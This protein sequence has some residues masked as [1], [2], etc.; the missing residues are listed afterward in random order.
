MVVL[1]H[2]HS[3]FLIDL[4]PKYPRD[5]QVYDDEEDLIIKQAFQCLCA[6]CEQEI[7]YLHRYYYKC[8][9]CDYSLHKL[10]EKI[11]TKLQHAS[12]SAHSLTLFLDESLGQCH[13]CKSTPRY[14][15]LKYQCPRC[16]F[17]ICLYCATG[18][19]QYHTIYHPS[20]QH[21][22]IPVCRQRQI[23]AE[24]D[25]CG[26]E[27]KGVYYECITCFDFL[28]HKDCVFQPKRLLIQDGTYGRFSHTHPLVLTYSFPIAHQKAK[29]YPTCRVCDNSFSENENI[30]VYKCDKC[31]YYAHTDCA[32]A[33]R[34]SFNSEYNE[35]S[36]ITFE[37]YKD[38]KDRY[39][40]LDLPLPDLSKNR[41]TALFSK[42]SNEMSITHNCHEHPLILVD[43]RC[44]DVTK[45]EDLCNGCDSPVTTMPFYKCANGCNF[46]LHEWCTRLPTELKGHPSRFRV[47]Y[48][49]L[50]AV[51][52]KPKAMLMHEDDLEETFGSRRLIDPGCL[53]CFN[54]FNGFAYY[55]AVRCRDPKYPIDVWFTNPEE[56]SFSCSLCN[57]HLHPKCALLLPETTRHK[58][59]KHPMTLCYRP[60]EN[61]EG[62]YFCEVCEEEMN[63]NAAF[64]HCHE[65]AQSMHTTCAPL[66]PLSK[67]HIHDLHV[68][69]SHETDVDYE[70]F[71]RL[72]KKITNL[73]QIPSSS[74]VVPR[75]SSTSS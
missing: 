47:Y 36:G 52:L 74:T 70:D 71:I 60:V 11:P 39:R 29:F 26:K 28:I 5:E 73:F 2:K 51:V 33:I 37:Q 64:Y 63:P 69:G 59:D 44:N 67:P 57:F 66:V 6:R 46:V 61:H 19:I 58:Y 23:L 34:W 43:S 8:D 40:V 16:M 62:D 3:L 20:H 56:T 22:L 45:V 21:P 54:H 38:Q 72:N 30:W 48:Q 14:K 42:E 24:C 68:K 25:A 50:H 18:D 55:C 53:V 4:N 13:I 10:C 31:R 27:H 12:H 49:G 17:N 41:F 15:Q 7:T 65:C 1:Q 32:N 35:Y 9:Q 75:S